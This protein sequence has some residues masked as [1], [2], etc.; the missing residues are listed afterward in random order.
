MAPHSSKA[1]KYIPEITSPLRGD[2]IEMPRVIAEC[3]GIRI[4]GKRIKS[5]IYT[6]DAA[7]AIN[8]NADALIAVYPF[9]PHP[10]ITSAIIGISPVPVFAGVGG[11]TTGG[12]RCA[13]IAMFAE[14]Q[15]AIGLVVNSPT[16]L[17]TIRD[18]R[19]VVDTPIVC[20]IV[21]EYMDIDLRV[22]AGVQIFNVSGAERTVDIVKSIRKRYPTIPIIATGGST[23]ET[24]LR[25]IESGANAITYT[26]PTSAQLFKIKMDKYRKMAQDEYENSRQLS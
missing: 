10:A 24:I 20:T 8:H 16:T 11:G 26:P 7:Q 23:D 18:I 6:T 5:I 21:S 15:G 1:R 19:A 3:S 14:A 17:E 2:I 9:T 22:E 4:F 12:K 25:T 13:Q